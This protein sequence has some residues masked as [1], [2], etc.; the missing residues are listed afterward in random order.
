MDEPP[1]SPSTDPPP[2]LYP[3]AP[4]YKLPKTSHY[5]SIETPFPIKSLPHVLSL[6]SGPLPPTLQSHAQTQRERQ[7]RTNIDGLFN[8]QTRSLEMWT[9]TEEEER[10]G[11]SRWRHPLM[12]EG[13]DVGRLLLKIKRRRRKVREGNNGVADA[14]HQDR[15]KG[16]GKAR[17]EH[18]I[19]NGNERI[20]TSTATEKN[21]ERGGIFKAEIIGVISRTVRFKGLSFQVL[22]VLLLLLLLYV[23]KLANVTTQC[24]LA[25]ADYQ[26]TPNQNDTIPKLVKSL[27]AADGRSS[28]PLRT[29]IPD[30]NPSLL[31]TL[32]HMFVAAHQ[33]KRFWTSNFHLSTKP[34]TFL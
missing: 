12:G 23:R 1:L 16:K 13:V 21:D 22:L 8:R 18:N 2:P 25:M 28:P 34:T 14:S 17:P 4:T 30:L 7:A 11:E 5:N 29:I 31:L 6:L 26:Y 10:I 32:T 9:A 33:L 15:R 27:Y 24:I 3:V 20:S 19:Q